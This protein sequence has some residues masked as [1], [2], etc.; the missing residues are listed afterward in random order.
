MIII[1]GDKLVGND[2]NYDRKRALA[3]M[4][5]G[6]GGGGEGGGGGGDGVEREMVAWLI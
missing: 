4:S 5:L 1:R 2:K 6:G 3:V